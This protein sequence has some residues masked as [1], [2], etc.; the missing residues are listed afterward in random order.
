[1]RAFV[2][3]PE[4]LLVKQVAPEAG[5]IVL[6]GLFT[7]LLKLNFRLKTCRFL[8]VAPY[9]GGRRV[10]ERLYEA[11]ASLASTLK[12]INNYNADFCTAAL[13]Y[14]LATLYNKPIL[15]V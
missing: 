4:S 13:N 10:N 8:S 12:I 2:W 1:M 11:T 9:S 15:I 14:W 5:V 6:K 3:E 7:Q